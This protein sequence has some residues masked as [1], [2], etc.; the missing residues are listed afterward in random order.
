M[1]KGSLPTVLLVLMVLASAE[2]KEP[3]ASGPAGQTPKELGF[4]KCGIKPEVGPCKALFERYYY[5][6]K[7]KTCRRFFWGG[8]QGVVPFETMEECERTCPPP[9]TLRMIELKAQ[10]GDVYATVSLE[11][12]KGWKRPEFAVAVDGR[13]VQARSGSGGFSTDRQMESLIFF[14]G[15][16]GR[17]QVTVRATV[18]GKQVEATGSLDWRP[19]ALV[20]LIGHTGDREL[21]LAKE[22]IRLVTVNV[23]EVDIAFNGQRVQPEP[24]GG[25]AKLFSFQPEWVGGKNTLTVGGKAPD[26]TPV[27]QGYSFVYLGDGSLVEGET[28]VLEYGRESSKSGPFFRVSVEGTSLVPVREG[29]THC[30]LLNS[31]GWIG[32]VTR[33]VQELKAERPGVSRVLLFEKPHFLMAEELKREIVI[34]VLPKP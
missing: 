28:V 30:Y 14:P 29:Q 7:S 27:H 9:Q 31:E 3:A 8:C 17:K 4:I 10:P 25:D 21:I 22:K 32:G 1:T 23:D 11:F 6:E 16:P 15:R 34:T 2:A 33:L 19:R 5:D 20:A 24:F 18:D 12:P 13:E 26:G